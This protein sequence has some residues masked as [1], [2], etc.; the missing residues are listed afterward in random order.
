MST[1]TTSTAATTAA[2]FHP[3]PRLPAKIR[4]RVWELTVQPRVVEVRVLYDPPMKWPPDR[5]LL[6]S[7]TP[8]PA[9]L[10]ACREAREHLTTCPNSAYRFD[11][12]LSEI[13]A[14]YSNDGAGGG[15]QEERGRYA[16]ISLDNDMLSI[17]KSDLHEFRDVALQ[18]RRLRLWRVVSDEYFARTESL[19]IGRWFRNVTEVHLIC[20]EGIRSGYSMTEDT[21]FPCGPENVYFVDPEDGTTMNSVE[22]DSMVVREAEELYG[23]EEQD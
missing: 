16:W 1:S 8:A 10:Q 23:P 6:R 11:K 4:A 5:R 7:P 19:L 12:A 18:V 14:T 17:D 13:T 9:Q 15:R 21:D 3:F 2:T 22:L 20:A